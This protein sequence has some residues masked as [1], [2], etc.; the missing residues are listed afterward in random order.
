VCE[1]SAS[2]DRLPVSNTS[3]PSAIHHSLLAQDT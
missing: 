3:K 2:D 1:F